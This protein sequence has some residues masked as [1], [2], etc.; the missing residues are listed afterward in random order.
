M[1]V[2]DSLG[3]H[4][5]RQLVVAGLDGRELLLEEQ[6]NL[7]GVVLGWVD[8]QKLHASIVCIFGKDKPNIVMLQKTM[9]F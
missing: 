1:D 4:V 6:V 2:A 3:G 9:Y 7:N 5:V 8:L